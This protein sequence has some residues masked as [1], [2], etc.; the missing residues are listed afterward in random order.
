[1]N[2]DEATRILKDAVE[3]RREARRAVR[4][5]EATIE[6]MALVIQG[7]LRLYP[8]LESGE[9]FEW[10]D[11]ETIDGEEDERPRGADAVRTILT[12]MADQW[13][14][15]DRV[16]EELDRRDWLPQSDNPSNAVRA[17]L[18]RARSQSEGRIEKARLKDSR[19]VVYRYA[20][21]VPS[22][23]DHYYDEEPF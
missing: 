5:G 11:P 10:G 17:A 3:A 18:E 9:E 21:P 4:Q 12:D 2:R 20:T 1:M 7:V 13:M 15:I 14:T 22:G 19:H 8:D 16:V 23:G 6:G